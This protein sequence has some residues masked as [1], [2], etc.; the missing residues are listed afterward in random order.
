MSEMI[1]LDIH[2]SNYDISIVRLRG[3][4]LLGMCFQ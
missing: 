4:I 3:V 2:A 1:I